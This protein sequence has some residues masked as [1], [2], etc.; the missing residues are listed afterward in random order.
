MARCF[1]ILGNMELSE[2]AVLFDSLGSEPRLRIFRILADSGSGGLAAGE[3][4]EACQIPANTSSFHLKELT[5]SGLLLSQREGRSIRYRINVSRTRELMRFLTV[6]LR[7]GNPCTELD[8]ESAIAVFNQIK[9]ME[10]NKETVLFVCQHNSARS[11]M[12]EALLRHYAGDEYNVYSGGYAPRPVDPKA[13]E[14]MKELD[15][16][17]S[18]QSPKGLSEF[19]GWTRI[20]H[21]IFVCESDEEDCPKLYP[22]CDDQERWNISPPSEGTTDEQ[23]LDNFRKSRDELKEKILD[24]IARKKEARQRLAG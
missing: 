14:V 9:T 19:M 12:A 7:L 20:L 23:I 24:W 5:S 1:D 2:L 6:D 18:Q 11:Q 15:I 16:D 8:S 17:I 4:A 3:V 10:P 22:F 13:V 21:T